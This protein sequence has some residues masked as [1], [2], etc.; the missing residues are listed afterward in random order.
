MSGRKKGLKIFLLFSALAAAGSALS[1][2]VSLTHSTPL[3]LLEYR[4]NETGL[5]AVSSGYVNELLEFRTSATGAPLVDAHSA[6]GA[7][8]SGLPGDRAFDNSAAVMGGTGI[9]ARTV[10]DVDA[11]DQLVS[12]TISAWYKTSGTNSLIGANAVR[13]FTDIAA[14]N[15]WSVVSLTNSFNVYGD[16]SNVGTNL[17]GSILAQSNEWVF[18]AITYDGT[19]T[20]NNLKIYGGDK[21]TGVVLLATRSL[22]SGTLED[23]DAPFTVGN[24]AGRDRA[25]SGYIDNVRLHGTK[26]AGDNSGALSL[27]QLESIRG[28]YI[29]DAHCLPPVTIENDL[30]EVTFDF[31]TGLLICVDK[32]IGKTWQQ[33]I[34]HPVLIKTFRKKSDT[35]F[36]F[37]F[38]EKTG[39]SEYKVDVSLGNG[40]KGKNQLCLEISGQGAM[41]PLFF[42]HPFKTEKGQRI[43]LP[44]SEGIAVP[45]DDHFVFPSNYLG[46]LNA[47]V[48][49]NFPLS[50]YGVVDDLTQAGIMTTIVTPDDAFVHFLCKEDGLHTVVQG[51]EPS[52]G[53]MRYTRQLRYTFFSEGGYVAMAKAHRA[54]LQEKGWI[55]TLAEKARENPNVEKLNGA[56]NIWYCDFYSVKQAADEMYAAGIDRALWSY[57]MSPGTIQRFNA[58]GWL[59]SCYDQCRDMMDPSDLPRVGWVPPEGV[60]HDAWPDSAVRNRDGTMTKGWPLA[61]IDKGSNILMCALSDTKAPAH[62]KGKLDYHLKN[63]HYNARFYDVLA[64]MAF[65]NE[66]WDPADRYTRTDARRAIAEIFNHTSNERNLVT[67]SEAGIE[68]LIENLHFLEGIQL[69]EPFRLPTEWDLWVRLYDDVSQLPERTESLLKASH[70]YQIPIWELVF[71]DCVVGYHRFQFPNNKWHGKQW[72]AR[73]DLNAVLFGQPQM[74]VFPQRRA[75]EYWQDNKDEVIASYTRVSHAVR[76]VFGAEMLNHEYLDD[77]RDI[78]RT[79]FANG[80]SVVVNYSDS[81]FQIP[82][83]GQ[84]VFAF[85]FIIITH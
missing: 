14:N 67:G 3:L 66:N 44:R 21:T 71:H 15:G 6:D 38:L 49:H 77:T 20:G 39:G 47:Y 74:F 9:V 85:D 53:E 30:L 80:V 13:L 1:M 29:I 46:R 76:Q 7:G 69:V 33:E 62:V 28:G 70:R 43:I 61:S 64:G 58:K 63:F 81:D 2:S 72:W 31:G 40:A 55:K 45:V 84:T 52:L 59:T 42:P 5:R 19:L 16:N 51:W 78:Q 82:D 23:N 22:N 57:R 50:F 25:F 32:R 27:D 36:T 41:N 12:F 79:T 68:S 37:S 65:C 48:G 34:L 56:A 4:F 35:S 75:Y 17:A 26:T 73:Q 60:Y 10:G 8:V 24:Q 54:Y 11:I 83:S 18:L